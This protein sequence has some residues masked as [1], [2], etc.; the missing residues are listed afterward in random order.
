MVLARAVVVAE[1]V[2]LEAEHGAAGAPG[3]P[4]EPVEGGGT[5]AAAPDDDVTVFAIHVSGRAP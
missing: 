3:G 5:E 4:G 2:G 1:V